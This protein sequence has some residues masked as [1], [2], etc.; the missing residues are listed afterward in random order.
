MV[1]RLRSPHLRIFLIPKSA[2][3]WCWQFRRSIYYKSKDLIRRRSTVQ[4]V[5]GALQ[6]LIQCGWSSSNDLGFARITRLTVPTLRIWNVVN[7]FLATILAAFPALHGL[8]DDL[9]KMMK[10]W[11]SWVNMNASKRAQSFG[12]GRTNSEDRTL[13]LAVEK[14]LGRS[15]SGSTEGVMVLRRI[16][17]AHRI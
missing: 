6:R 10:S 7:K 5:F 13:G 11:S 14:E 4:A 15:L 3:G 12:I 2:W 16:R 1:I 9:M 17:L 8:T